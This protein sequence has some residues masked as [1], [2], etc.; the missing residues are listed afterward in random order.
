MVKFLYL[1]FHAVIF[2]FRI[3]FYLFQTDLFHPKVM[4]STMSEFDIVSFPFFF[5]F[6]F[7][8]WMGKFPVL[9]LTAYSI[10]ESQVM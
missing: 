2:S 7:F 9:L 1:C 10:S 8:F 5:F 4:I 3:Y 6:F